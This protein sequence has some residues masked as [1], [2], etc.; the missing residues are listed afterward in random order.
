M[1]AEM[2]P[3]QLG[4]R[5]NFEPAPPG[6]IV[7]CD[8]TKLHVSKLFSILGTMYSQVAEL[9]LLHIFVVNLLGDSTP[10]LARAY[11]IASTSS[12]C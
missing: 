5:T 6:L 7:E 11:L 10:S 3:V 1:L 8:L 9:L 12:Q 2:M 4:V